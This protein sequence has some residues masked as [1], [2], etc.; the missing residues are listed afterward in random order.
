MIPC[1]PKARVGII[2]SGN[3]ARALAKRLTNAG[4]H[5]II[6]TRRPRSLSEVDSCLCNVTVTSLQDCVKQV[7]IV[8]LAIHFENYKDCLVF[9]GPAV[10]Y[11]YGSHFT[12]SQE[13]TK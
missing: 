13:R 8:F 9:I 10:P 6:G 1:E 5:V 4:Y 11:K 7:P 2:G 3:F 12:L